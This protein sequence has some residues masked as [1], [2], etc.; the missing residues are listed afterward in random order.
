MTLFLVGVG[1]ALLLLPGL[2]GSRVLHPRPAPWSRLYAVSLVLG[3]TALLVGLLLHAAPVL[4]ALGHP[5]DLSATDDV[6]AHLSPG[7]VPAALISSVL[8]ILLVFR[9]VRGVLRLYRG[10]RRSRAAPCL[11]THLRRASHDLVVLPIARSVAYSIGGKPS[12]VVV[13]EELVERLAPAELEALVRHEQSHL[14]NS[15]QHYLAVAALVEQAV[16]LLPLVRTGTMS[17]RIAIERWADE[18]A[19]GKD[20]AG[21]ALLRQ[22]MLRAA[23]RDPADWSSIPTGALLERSRA[24]AE[25]PV[26]QRDRLEVVVFIA[27]LTLL[28][29]AGGTLGHWV[30]DVPAL[31]A[32]LR[33]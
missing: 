21:R 22:A 11:G 19:A 31:L 18:D 5:E 7:G 12:Q 26:S 8:A 27:V 30:G 28:V 14:L 3:L 9:L 17:L 13:S 1:L 24:L 4:A 29:V 10:R 32:F 23:H 20:R 16:G 6:I 2:A 25:R 33:S 15:H